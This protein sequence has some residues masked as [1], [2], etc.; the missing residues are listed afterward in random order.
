METVKKNEASLNQS[1]F[2]AG[3]KKKAIFNNNSSL[4]MSF[5]KNDDLSNKNKKLNKKEI[6]IF[7]KIFLIS[8]K[9]NKLMKM[10]S[11]Y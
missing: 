5:Q 7:L 3:G 9:N 10:K 8:M 6:K 11:F 4:F 1:N 2:D